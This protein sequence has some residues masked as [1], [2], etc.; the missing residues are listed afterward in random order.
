[1][2]GSIHFLLYEEFG[3]HERVHCVILLTDGHLFLIAMVK[4]WEGVSCSRLVLLSST[5]P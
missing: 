1:M 2:N 3:T 4:H 5:N